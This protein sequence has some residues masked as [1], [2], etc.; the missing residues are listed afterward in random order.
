MQ[1]RRVL[2]VAVLLAATIAL[3]H[4]QS[5]DDPQQWRGV[6][7]ARALA[8][9]D[10]ID[11]PYRR[12]E[13]LAS[14]ARVQTLIGET[15][16]DRTIHLA[17]AAVAQIREPAFRDWVLNDVVLAQIAAEDLAGAR[18]TANRIEAK[19]QQGAALVQIATV[20]LRAGNIAGAQQTAETIREREAKSEV[21]RQLVAIAAARG[22]LA[23]ARD[24]L[25][26]IDDPF[27]QALAAGDIAVAE[28]RMGHNDRADAMVGRVRRADRAQVY[29]RVALARADKGDMNGA[30]ATLQKI[31]DDLYRA[32]MQGR[33]A[34]SRAV[35]G[36]TTG[37]K[38]MF[39]TAIA[40]V[41]AFPREPERRAL[42]FGQLG[43]LQALSGDRAAAMQTLTRALREAQKL[44]RGERREDTL[45]HIARGMA[46]AGDSAGALQTAL[47]MNDR[48]QRALLVR[49]V[50][51]M[52]ANADSG[53]AAASAAE[54]SDPLIEAAAQ[55]GVL[56]MQMLRATTPLSQETIEAAR[57]AVRKIDEKQP[58]PAAFAALAA[59]RVKTG[60]VDQ[61]T[62]IFNEALESAD[63]IT[64]SDQRAAAYVDMVA[65]LNDRLVFLGQPVS[66]PKEN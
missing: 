6:A 20:E 45:D 11:D 30:V 36:D 37:A 46:R 41:E 59:A 12:A 55:F 31:D 65:A 19:R 35:A 43:R 28:V 48:V 29:G 8:A 1:F 40:T 7:L 33:L 25:R 23:N 18:E 27:Y 54:F 63:A 56:G 22:D 62:S 34:A 3:A 61:G 32:A 47:Q 60:N 58:K 14:I 26:D 10:T 17:L 44:E 57:R 42:T 4:T 49:D 9:A 52:Q 50:V 53:S 38:Q 2:S 13:T 24:I 21:L 5:L 66:A 51:T 39:E 16:S 64:R 15:A